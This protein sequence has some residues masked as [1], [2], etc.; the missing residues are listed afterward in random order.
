MEDT[1][2]S[3]DN[4]ICPENC[5]YLYPNEAKQRQLFRYTNKQVNHKWVILSDG[6]LYALEYFDLVCYPDAYYVVF[7]KRNGTWE[8]VYQSS[9]R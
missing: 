9:A 5:P 4:T 3:I 2:Q 7:A 1:T 8:K 6:L